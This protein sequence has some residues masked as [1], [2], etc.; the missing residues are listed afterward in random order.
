MSEGRNGKAEWLRMGV[1]FAVS[2]I[3]A[4]FT[5][6]NTLNVRVTAI[7]TRE[8]T[9]FE[10]M[11]RTLSRIESTLLRQEDHYQRVLDDWRN[12]IDRRTGEPL[13]LQRR[14]EDGR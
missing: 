14:L 8:Q 7:D 2:G 3:V 1:V 12:G 13:P 10:E 6:I 9:R 5:A 4:Y 11:Q